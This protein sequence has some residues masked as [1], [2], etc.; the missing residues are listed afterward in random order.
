MGH[1]SRLVLASAIA[2]A[3]GCSSNPK[4]EEPAPPGDGA[5]M[6][7]PG[8]REPA[9][10]PGPASDPGPA[11]GVVKRTGD[12]SVPDDYT[13]MEGDCV[14]LGRKLGALWRVELRSGLSPKLTEKQREKAER[15][16]EEG[17]SKKE[18]DWADGCVKS[19]VGKSVDPK[20]LKC[21]FDAKDLKA[22]EACLN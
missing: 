7:D 11:P 22:F 17:A 18:E 15:S 2:L 12:N 8:D 16:I 20:A 3:C 10:D 5:A 1:L 6:S 14:Q 9:A 19:L 4:P 13:L 21:A